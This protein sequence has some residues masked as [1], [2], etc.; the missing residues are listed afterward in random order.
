[1][2]VDKPWDTTARA[3]QLQVQNA[4]AEIINN[5]MSGKTNPTG[6]Y[7]DRFG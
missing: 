2:E 4:V 5:C 6:G 7:G 1:M 3:S